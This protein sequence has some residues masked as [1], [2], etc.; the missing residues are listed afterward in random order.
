MRELLPGGAPTDL[1]A[2]RAAKL[3]TRIRPSSPVDQAHEELARELVEDIRRLDARLAANK[4]DRQLTPV[5]CR[6]R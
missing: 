1:T 3:L 6:C 2:D 5:V 4:S